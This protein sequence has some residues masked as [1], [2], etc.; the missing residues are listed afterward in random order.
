MSAIVAPHTK[1]LTPDMVKLGFEEIQP[2]DSTEPRLICCTDA[3]EKQGKS[4]WSFTA[5]GPVIGV[6]STDAGTREVMRKFLPPVTNKRFIYNS[7]AR[8]KDMVADKANE[9]TVKRAWEHAK[10][11]MEALVNN[12][13]VRTIVTDTATELWELCR[14]ARFGKLVQV[15]PNQY[16]PVNNE[17]RKTILKLPG[18]RDGLNAVFVHKT[19]KEYRGK[20]GKDSWT[21]KMERAGF[22]D[23]PYIADIVIKH[24]RTDLDPDEND[25]QRCRF[26]IRVLDSRF[27]PTSL[28]GM[29][30]EGEDNTFA[31]LAQMCFPDTDPEYWE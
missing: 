8:A 21:G 11:C 12:K 4:H 3:G 6:L 15:M 19:K 18:E 26:G 10:D 20:D 1:I 29:E 9:D 13:Q 30:F 22:A 23:A 27:E 5:P 2:T 7:I 24:Y 14:L 31:M 17:F 16:G 28:I 25:G